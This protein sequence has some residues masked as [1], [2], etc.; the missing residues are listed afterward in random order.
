MDSKSEESQVDTQ[1]IQILEIAWRRYAQLSRRASALEKERG[2]GGLWIA[3]LG[4]LLVSLAI[5]FDLYTDSMPDLA[6]LVVKGLFIVTP[7]LLAIF[8]VYSRKPK[9]ELE[10][11]AVCGGVEEV[12]KNI[13]F[14]RSVLQHTSQRRHWLG[15]RLVAVQRQISEAIGRELTLEP[16]EGEIRPNSLLGVEGDLGITDLS[17]EE[18][19]HF[20][21]EG[22]LAQS[23][24][25]STQIQGKRSRWIFVILLVGGTGALLAAFGGDMT[26]WAGLV[27]SAI[28]AQY[29][30]NELRKIGEAQ[31][32]ENKT[33]NELMSIYDRWNEHSELDRSPKTYYQ[34]VQATE[35]ILWNRQYGYIQKVQQSLLAQ[36]GEQLVNAVV[37]QLFGDQEI[38]LA[39]E[40]PSVE[41]EL[42]EQPQLIVFD[43]RGDSV[44]V[45]SSDKIRTTAVGED[46]ELEIKGVS[47]ADQLKAIAAE[48]TDVPL[49]RSTP[50]RVIND[51][52]GRFVPDGE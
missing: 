41:K 38:W 14:Y 15:G 22:Q 26:V 27:A 18:Y 40:G 25:R 30:W 16:Y 7:I 11:E 49:N 20:R 28:I 4:L 39:V 12:L 1:G 3:I 6:A 52:L 50:T 42:V 13:Y 35:Q 10:R 36:E 31:R 33:V 5:V 23:I 46:Q 29:G 21:L 45:S 51:V 2:R 24:H 47:Y 32:I 34:L 8:A 9:H 48:F 17:G 19:V 37:C 43:Q 44:K